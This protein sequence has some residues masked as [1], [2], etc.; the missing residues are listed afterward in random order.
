M[1]EKENID[2]GEL[3]LDRP[4]GLSSPRHKKQQKIYSQHITSYGIIAYCPKSDQV[5]I[6]RRRD[7]IA[8]LDLLRGRYNMKNFHSLIGLLTD[9]ERKRLVAYSFDELWEDLWV[10]T[11]YRCYSLEYEKCKEQFENIQPFLHKIINVTSPNPDNHMWEFP[12][13]KP[14]KKE[15]IFFTA[16]REFEE[17]TRLSADILNMVNEIPPVIETYKGTDKKSY[18]TIYYVM[19]VQYTPLPKVQK[20]SSKIRNYTISEETIQVQWVKRNYCSYY[21][22][23]RRCKL[24]DYV[25]SKYDQYLNIPVSVSCIENP[26]IVVQVP[27]II[28]SVFNN[29]VSYRDILIKNEN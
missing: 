3:K 11:D 22:N 26:D 8:Y 10:N 19:T 17:E 18:K 27:Q 7:S 5:L 13:G 21:L 16:L 20:L 28:Y 1:E 9:E 4:P 23:Q 2:E 24:L 6:V 14:V 25:F 15:P 12:K 29:S